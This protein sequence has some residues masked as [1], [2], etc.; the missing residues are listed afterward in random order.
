MKQV[1]KNMEHN[2]VYVPQYDCKGFT[3]KIGDHKIKLSEKTEQMAVAWIRKRQSAASPPDNVFMRN[4]MNEFLDELKNENSSLIFL[5]SFKSDYLKRIEEY[6]KDDVGDSEAEIHKP[7]DLSEVSD[8]VE[9]E[10]LKKAE[11]TKE[12]KKALATE[13]KARRE[14]LKEKYGYATVNGK[15]RN[16]QLDG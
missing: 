10:K 15:I 4:F 11:M 3:I 12:E 2:G 5:D 9:G 16:C 8:Y 7:I 14:K 13:L 6:E 1:L